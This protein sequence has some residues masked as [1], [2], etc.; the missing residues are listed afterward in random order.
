MLGFAAGMMLSGSFFSLIV[1]GLEIWKS[2]FGKSPLPGLKAVIGILLGAGLVAAIDRFSP[3]EH[4]ILGREGPVDRSL[5]RIWLFVIAITIH[6]IPEGLAV[7][8]GFSGDDVA[9]GIS[10]A[11]GIGLQNLPEG[12]AVAM[13]LS[14]EGYSRW[15]AFGIASMTGLVEPVGGLL[16]SAAVSV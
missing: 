16:G 8:V 2:D 1:P 4:F 13:A 5:R 11:T 6:N 10:L 14:G 9:R 3:H 12:L 15:K 7:G